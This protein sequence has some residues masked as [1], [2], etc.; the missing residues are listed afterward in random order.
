MTALTL[1]YA[2][3]DKDGTKLSFIDSGAPAH[4]N[5]YLTFVVFHGLS[6]H[7]GIFQWVLERAPAKNVRFVAVNRRGYS[8]STPY[9]EEELEEMERG[10]L[11]FLERCAREVAAFLTWFV[12]THTIPKRGAD[13]KGCLAVGGYSL[14]SMLPLA[15]L[16]N[17][18]AIPKEQYDV[19]VPYLTRVV[20]IDSVYAAQGVVRPEGAYLPFAD[21]ELTT[22][23]AQLHA[24]SIF[25]TSYYS[26]PNI[27]CGLEG[28]D[29]VSKR[30]ARA[31]F[32]ISGEKTKPLCDD[33]AREELR[34]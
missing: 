8:S 27:E 24:F 21:S 20:L 7:A 18:E 15:L 34:M 19:L 23:E 10:N 25:I 22:P 33:Y 26:H 32:E 16:G 28:M 9:N 12:K 3:V 13:G 6:M 2:P 5:D 1:E 29:L 17:P 14:G 11:V 30:T 31:S 4:S